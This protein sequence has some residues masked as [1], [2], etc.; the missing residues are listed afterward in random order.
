M[1]ILKVG[2]KEAKNTYYKHF[3][4]IHLYSLACH[5]KTILFR[6]TLHY[7]KT[8]FLLDKLVHQ[9]SRWAT[10]FLVLHKIIKIEK[11]N[12]KLVSN[13]IKSCGFFLF[14]YVILGGE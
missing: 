1:S 9:S 10:L 13:A 7:R 14:F 3:H 12:R 2:G 6:Y 5:Y 8:I 11:E 4:Q